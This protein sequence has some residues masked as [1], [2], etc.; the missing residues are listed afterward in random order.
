MLRF[1]STIVLRPFP[2]RRKEWVSAQRVGN[3]G[4]LSSSIVTTLQPYEQRP[5]AVRYLLRLAYL[6]HRGD[7]IGNALMCL[8]REHQMPARAAD[9]LKQRASDIIA[10]A[11]ATARLL[12]PYARGEEHT[13]E[14]RHT[15]DNPDCEITLPLTR[16]PSIKKSVIP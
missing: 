14:S 2:H 12:Q 1:C 9:E 7:D 10:E 11:F 16:A 5:Q 8:A 3:A 13:R 15:S 6:L 4:A